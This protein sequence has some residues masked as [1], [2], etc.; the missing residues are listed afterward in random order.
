[1][2]NATTSPTTGF[3]ALDDAVESMPVSLVAGHS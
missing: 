2:V 3:L 1:M